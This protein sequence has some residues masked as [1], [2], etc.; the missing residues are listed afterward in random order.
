M[1]DIPIV[2]AVEEAAPV[3]STVIA[4]PALDATAKL[5]AD[6]RTK[7]SDAEAARAALRAERDAALIDL[8]E[9]E[10]KIDSLEAARDSLIE[11]AH[12]ANTL[13]MEHIEIPISKRK[14]ICTLVQLLTMPEQRR[15]SDDELADHL[16]AGWE[17]LHIDIRSA[18]WQA[19]AQEAFTR[20][21]TLAREV[22]AELVQPSRSTATFIVGASPVISFQT[23]TL[24]EHP[25]KVADQI[26]FDP[27][28]LENLPANEIDPNADDYTARVI[29]S[30][31]PA[32][33][34][35]ELLTQYT[36]RKIAARRPAHTPFAPSAIPAVR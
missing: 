16:N 13:L 1:T 21:V 26:I 34:K 24:V 4:D 22:A 27:Q 36:T 30:R 3:P 14:A 6:L 35:M 9:A 15:R 12:V 18:F 19:E 2:L 29:R 33:R 17:V 7:L 32:A 25:V 31:L 5:I 10:D 8:G 20:I 23:S 11:Q 28:R